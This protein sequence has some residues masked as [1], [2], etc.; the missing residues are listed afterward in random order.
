MVKYL[1]FFLLLSSCGYVAR[2][3]EMIGQ[4]KK[5]ANVTPLFCPDRVDVDLSLG[6]LRNGVGSMSTEDVWATV[7]KQNV[8]DTLK[9]AN[10]QGAIV[11]VVYNVRRFIICGEQREI[12]GAEITK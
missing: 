10:S 5:I 8:I 2:D 3:S 6:V 4:I 9:M 1:S 12:I 7:Y 11:K